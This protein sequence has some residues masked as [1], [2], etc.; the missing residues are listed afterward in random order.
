MVYVYVCVFGPHTKYTFYQL[1]NNVR[2]VRM[3]VF[4]G[5][6]NIHISMGSKIKPEMLIPMLKYTAAPKIVFYKMTK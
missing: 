6:P 2:C 4:D 1:E 5:M 3:F